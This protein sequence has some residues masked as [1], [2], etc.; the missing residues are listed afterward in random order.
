MLTSISS[1]AAA[2]DV[3]TEAREDG[4]IIVTAQRREENLQDVPAS[5][6]AL[7]N[8]TLEN[9]QVRNF[10]DYV[11]YLPSASFTTGSTGVPGNAS[12][13]FR[14]ITTGGGLVTSGTLP[15]V[16]SYLDE[17]PITSIL[18]TVDI[19]VYDIARVE[20]LA[21]PQ[22]TL[23]GA[24]SQAGVVRI[25]TNKP[26]PDSF[27]ARMDL[28]VNRI[29]NGDWG[30]QIEGFVNLPVLDGRGALRLVGWYE[31]TG[32][33]V[34]NMLGVRTFAT[35]RITQRNDALVEDDHNPVDKIGMRASLGIDLDDNWTVMPSIIA[36]RTK[37][38]GSFQSDDDNAGELNVAHY[39]PE[40]GEDEWYQ[41]GL[42]INGR[43]AD[44]DIVYAGYYLD[45]RIDTQNDYS[46]YGF[47][48]DLV[49]GSGSGVVDN[50]GRLIDPSQ[51][52]TNRFRLNK[53]SQ[54]LRIS[55]PQGDRFRGQVGLFYQRQFQRDENNY[56]TPGFADRL[57]VPGR[58]GQVWL[59]LQ[60]RVDRDYAAFAQADFDV[61]D[62]LLL[63]GGVRAYKF[64]NS[65]VGF[66]GVNT[67]FFGTGVRQCLGRA[68]GGGPFGVGVAVVPGSPCTNLGVLNPDGTISPKRSKGDGFTYRANAT[69]R[70]TDD[71]LVFATFSTGFRPGGINR[72]GTAEAF[73]ADELFNYEIGT[74]N[75]FADG[76]VTL[77]LTAF[78][79]DW[80]DV[81]VTF[82]PPGGSGVVLIGNVG[83]ARSKGIEGD[84][85]WRA[86]NGFSLTAAATYIDAALREPFV[87]F[88]KE[89][90]PAGQRLP[91]TPKFKG[92]LIA[93]YEAGVGDGM[94]HLQLAG[95][96][97][98]QRNPVITTSDLAKTGVLP[99][100]ATLDFS[101]GYRWDDWEVEIYGRNMTDSRGQQSRA[102]R[103][104]IN[105]CGPSAADP[106]GQV[107]R[108]YIQPAT[109]G[110]RIGRKF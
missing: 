63:T 46:D 73:D 98:G 78:L 15:T 68:Q 4:V 58:P 89:T 7:T 105:I 18:G 100:Y 38:D 13:S 61:T 36:Q 83:S 103:C 9:L 97:I 48:Y 74:K 27:S 69:Y 25:I 50:A 10:V 41:A 106:V 77:N 65:L 82:Q 33:F 3:A 80:K 108:I 2:Q 20:A 66:F 57:S 101:V 11:A 109:M 32:G 64:D 107:Y 53:L 94:A 52:N 19:H 79:A 26:D 12:I 43:I 28:E 84:I 6:I 37:W 17:Q 5:V 59:T 70:I 86:G 85:A 34:D 31:R 99:E 1:A 42:T 110:L 56:L 35:S 81:Q 95:A 14:G 16:G 39:Y 30:G 29:R 22:G 104:N 21:G 55:S 76:R 45:R 92:N 67:T 90:A 54:E 75:T 72:A 88:G 87:L 24:S 62:R 51:I 47:F 102:A 44:F 93:R 96:Y 23:Y 40:F 49:A 71:N 60:D 8:E 91:L